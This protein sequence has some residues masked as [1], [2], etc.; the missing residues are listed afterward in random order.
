[1]ALS[2]LV[3]LLEEGLQSGLSLGISGETEDFQEALE[4]D[5]LAVAVLIDQSKDLLSITLE[6]EHLDSGPQLERRDVAA[7]VVVEHVEAI[8]ELGDLVECQSRP[9]VL[10]QRSVGA[11]DSWGRCSGLGDCSGDSGLGYG[12][13]HR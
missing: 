5:L 12:S 9:D 2:F 3:E 11:G 8:L 10:L 6:T 13:A 4:V 1:M 7:P